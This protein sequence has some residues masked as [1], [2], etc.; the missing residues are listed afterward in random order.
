MSA[1]YNEH[2]A[3]AAAW[4]RELIA[5]G[6]IAEGKDDLEREGYALGS[7]GLPACSVEAPHIRQRLWFVADAT[8]AYRRSGERRTE[9]GTRPAGERRRGSASGGASG[10]LADPEGQR[11]RQGG[12][13]TGGRSEGVSTEG[14]GVG[15]TDAGCEQL[16]DGSSPARHRSDGGSS[17]AEEWIRGGSGDSSVVGHA[18][19]HGLQRRLPGRADA[20]HWAREERAAAGRTG[21]G[22]ELGHADS[23]G[24]ERIW[25]PEPRWVE[26]PRGEQSRRP[27]ERWTESAPWAEAHGAATTDTHASLGRVTMLR[28][29]G[30]AIVPQVA[31]AFI[32]A[33]DDVR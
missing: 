33:Y 32:S 28:G 8:H 9:A 12:Q 19:Q 25:E 30:N 17:A 26:G 18:K 6:Q 7:V 27:R 11:Q 10:E 29:A 13:D 5:D 15:P 20:Q 3:G 24:L 4:L 21:P 22:V 1:Y 14:A 2:D 23:G 16:A 31:A